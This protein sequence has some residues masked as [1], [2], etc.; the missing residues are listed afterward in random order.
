MEITNELIINNKDKILELKSNYENTS[1]LNDNKAQFV[2]DLARLFG[3]T[4]RTIYREISNATLEPILSKLFE[5]VSNIDNLESPEDSIKLGWVKRGLGAKPISESQIR[6]VQEKSKSAFDASRNLGVSYNTYKKYAK[7]YGIFEDLKNPFGIGI[8]KGLP[9]K[10]TNKLTEEQWQ[11]RLKYQALKDKHLHRYHNKNGDIDY[12]CALYII[13]IPKGDDR[14]EYIKKW[15]N[16]PIKIGISKDIVKRYSKLILQK[17]Y[18]YSNDD[19]WVEWNR[20]AEVINIIP[21]YTTE[22]CIRVESRIHTYIRD[23]RISGLYNREGNEVCELFDAPFEK[24]NEAIEI[25]AT[26]WRSL[27]WDD[28][29]MNNY[30]DF[31]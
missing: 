2:K 31:W 19:N 6:T 14:F 20:L 5:M 23:Y 10:K 25:Y 12:G 4:T 22:E 21:F 3:C 24:I 7:L 13:T 18:A 28:D 11:S 27:K 29:E 16:L 26:A 1:I 8:S 30:Y 9:R 15:G 17:T